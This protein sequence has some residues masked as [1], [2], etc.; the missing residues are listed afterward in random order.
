MI[1]VNASFQADG[2]VMV[3]SGGVIIGELRTGGRSCDGWLLPLFCA[4]LFCAVV[5]VALA[6]MAV[7]AAAAAAA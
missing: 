7:V 4:A 3:G 1:G 2:L 6:S 5:A